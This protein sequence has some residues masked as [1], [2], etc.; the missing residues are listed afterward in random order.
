MAD[1]TNREGSVFELLDG[2]VR[3]WVEQEAIHMIAGDL[4]HR[5]PVE[6]TSKMARQLA[7]ALKEMAD[8][9]ED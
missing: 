9:L 7:I 5:D 8:R 4:Q 6:L 1:S 2:D 3:I